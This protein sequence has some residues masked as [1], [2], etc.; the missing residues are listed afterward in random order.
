VFI[1][2]FQFGVF[3]PIF[4]IHGKGERALFSKNWD[5]PTKAILLKYDQLRYRLLPYIY[6]MAGAVTQKNYTPM[7]SLAFDFR[8][9]SNVY[10]I[11][12]QY[13]FGPAFL[14]NPVT[15]PLFTGANANHVAKSR[16]VYLPKKTQWIDFW[17]GKRLE[18]GRSVTA[19]APLDILPLYVRAGSIVPMGPYL[20]YATEKPA[21][22]IELRIYPG[23]DGKFTIYED[24]NDGY[25]YE[26]GQFATIPMGW[27]DRGHVL[28]IGKEQGTF[29]GMEKHHVFNIVI[30]KENK[31]T[32]VA[33]A[34]RY[35]ISADYDGWEARIKV[36]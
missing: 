10:R 23:A 22:T 12:D 30:V 19:A 8:E 35:D 1:R 26:N 27:D 18:G 36:P 17:T 4:R 32:G 13:M 6:S 21:D 33:P 5:V 11:P 14:V 15:R 16:N 2:W 34:S 24:E 29:P 9:D 28:T 25:D 7:R 31:A 20:E 3:S